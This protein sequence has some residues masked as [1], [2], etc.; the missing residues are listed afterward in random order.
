MTANCFLHQ[1][2]LLVVKNAGRL[3]ELTPCFML[4]FPIRKLKALAFF[5]PATVIA[6]QP[7]SVR[8]PCQE[9]PD[10]VGHRSRSGISHR[11]SQSLRNRRLK[12]DSNLPSLALRA[13]VVRTT[14]SNAPTYIAPCHVHPTS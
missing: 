6:W 4:D 8:G 9:I 3:I 7:C 10:R 1:S 14:S 11:T 12:M 2:P 13:S 5:D